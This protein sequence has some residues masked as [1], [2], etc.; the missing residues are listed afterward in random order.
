VTY[1]IGNMAGIR[2]ARRRARDAALCIIEALG[3]QRH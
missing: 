1:A 3:K 2:Q